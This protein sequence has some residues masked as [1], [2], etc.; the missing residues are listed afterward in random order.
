MKDNFDEQFARFVDGEEGAVAPSL[1]PIK[2]K[3]V[4]T[5]R[6]PI[7]RRPALKLYESMGRVTAETIRNAIKPLEDRIAA[8]ESAPTEFKGIWTQGT[9]YAAR[10]IISHD[11]SMWHANETTKDKPGT[12]AS[13]TRCVKRCRDRRSR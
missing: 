11:G 1:Q 4:P 6:R 3:T 9:K 10:S 8:L 2:R 5:R 13:W 12:S 7:K